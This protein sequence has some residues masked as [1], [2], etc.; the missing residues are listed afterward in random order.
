MQKYGK[1]TPWSRWNPANRWTRVSELKPGCNSSRDYW[2]TY[3]TDKMYSQLPHVTLYH[4]LE[5]GPI[6]MTLMLTTTI[7]L[8]DLSKCSIGIWR[9]LQRCT[10]R[11]AIHRAHLVLYVTVWY[12]N[13]RQRW[14][15]VDNE[16]EPRE[17]SATKAMW[18]SNS[19]ISYTICLSQDFFS[20][21]ICWRKFRKIEF[22]NAY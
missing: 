20:W 15:S 21:E 2:L 17:I 3:S 22:S 8:M 14:L 10:K 18:I 19:L 16:E 9:F 11:D 6:L 1:V 4:N 7:S 13:Q 5:I 12:S